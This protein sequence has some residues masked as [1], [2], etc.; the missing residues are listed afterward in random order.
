MANLF[1]G[2]DLGT[3]NCS[4]AYVVDDPRHHHT[5]S[6]PVHT[7]GILA[8]DNTDAKTYRVP[9][10]V[11]ASRGRG[12]RI[13]TLFGWKFHNWFRR[14]RRSAPLLRK[15]T[16]FFSSVKSD[17][18][19]NRVYPRSVVPAGQT[20]GQITTLIIKNLIELTRK[21]HRT[22]DVRRAN[23]TITV[24]A[25]FGA[26]ARKETLTA[27]LAA[28]LSEERISLIDEPVAALVDLL[29][30]AQAAT[31]LT[32]EFKNV[33]V[34]DYGAGT[35]DVALVRARFDLARQTGLE[36]VNLAISPYRRLGGDDIDKAVMQAV[37]WPAIATSKERASLSLSVRRQ[38]EDTFTGTIARELKQRICREVQRELDG[39]RSWE[40]INRHVKAY[41]P[42]EQ[43][44]AVE[45]LG[46]AT[47]R[48]FT[49]TAS[50]FAS[51]MRPFLEMPGPS[52]EDG[53][54]L[55]R[56]IL[57][58]LER[59]ELRA[60]Q[61]DVV[62]LHG[63]S[64]LNPYVEA[65]LRERLA[66]EVTL[67][68]SVEVIRTPDPLASVAR[69]AALASYWRHARKIELVRPIASEALGIVLKNGSTREFVRAGQALPFPEEDALAVVD[70]ELVVPDSGLPE[71]L[72]PVYTGS[73]DTPRVAGTIKVP[74]ADG[75]PAGA[76][77]RIKLNISRDKTLTWWF[78][79]G[80]GEFRK[81]DSVND[82]WTR[83]ALQPAEKRL[84]EHRR[85]MRESVEAGRAVSPRARK[86]EV[87][88]LWKAGALTE[89]LESVNDLLLD[90]GHSGELLNLKALI[91]DASGEKEE[92]LI[93]FRQATETDGASA[94]YVGNVGAQL[95]DL[96]RRSEALAHL[97]RALS[98]NPNLAYVYEQLADLLRQEGD[99]Q[100]AQR[101][102]RRGLEIARRTADASPLSEDAWWQV[103]RLRWNLGEYEEAEAAEKFATELAQNEFYGGDSSAIIT[104]PF[105]GKAWRSE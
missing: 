103:A 11:A 66:R 84:R 30:D 99:E 60:N 92:A 58:T 82:P 68:S 81:A 21:D 32:N 48:K 27:A 73:S 2:I 31:V 44:F 10:I 86:D 28:G 63:G 35:C 6:I 47:P 72:V 25:S 96:G 91:L 74:L 65:M 36:V 18:G 3:G 88:L 101:E 77:V 85:L 19:T 34:F 59:A 75:T 62:V 14:K 49:I 41:A 90:A 7:V 54:S 100:G 80:L 64:S 50:E 1:F 57:E 102:L 9:S 17:M 67:F 52:D 105:G 5:K 4:V 98:I 8:D 78:S 42:A 70:H 12:G 56:P 79:V 97:R 23:V 13:E 93:L 69:G 89:A 40:Q 55:M 33:M 94:V 87:Y 29:N 51:V 83:R 16:D 61:L 71:L 20:P 22:H 26:L 53:Q 24:P 46:R 15:G 43:T 37:V 38:V 95:A 104:S 76:P 39:K 45:G